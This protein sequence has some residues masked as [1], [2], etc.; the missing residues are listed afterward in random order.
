MAGVLYMENQ[1]THRLYTYENKKNDPAF[2]L[3]LY[4]YVCSQPDLCL[5]IRRR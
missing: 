1:M 5:C 3:H 4:F 2:T